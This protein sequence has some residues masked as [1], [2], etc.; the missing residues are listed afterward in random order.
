[1]VLGRDCFDLLGKGEG[2]L[3][4]AAKALGVNVAAAKSAFEAAATPQ[5]K[6]PVGTFQGCE[7]PSCGESGK[8]VKGSPGLW[9]KSHGEKLSAVERK[10]IADQ[11]KRLAAPPREEKGR[12]EL[13]AARLPSET[14]ANSPKQHI[15]LD[16]L[17][18]HG[19]RSGPRAAYHCAQEN[20]GDPAGDRAPDQNAHYVLVAGPHADEQ[21]AGAQRIQ[22]PI[23]SVRRQAQVDI[24]SDRTEQLEVQV[25]RIDMWFHVKKRS[26]GDAPEQA[27]VPVMQGRFPSRA[28]TLSRRRTSHEAR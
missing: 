14:R 7:I 12:E 13:G 17:C 8:R 20:D 5:A 22:F 9:C 10:S 1:V 18:E 4:V 24:K 15:E 16:R 27:D 6:A 21:Q 23:D 25:G 28:A 2:D 19:G 11:A 3:V 26:H